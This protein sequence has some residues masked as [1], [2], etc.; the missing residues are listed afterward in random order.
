V[1]LES[2]ELAARR[3]DPAGSSALIAEFVD[4]P[5][6]S[7]FSAMTA[8]SGVA[9]K[10]YVSNK[11]DCR[12]RY[13]LASPTDVEK[14][15]TNVTNWP[16]ESWQSLV[17][18]EPVVVDPMEWAVRTSHAFGG[19]GGGGG[20]ATTVPVAVNTTG[21]SA[22]VEALKVFTPAL[23]PSVHEPTAAIPDASV[24]TLAPVTEPPPLV[25]AKLTV[26]PA[27]G[28]AFW[29]VTRTDGAGETTLFAALVSEVLVV[30]TIAVGTGGSTH[31]PPSQAMHASTR[32]VAIDLNAMRFDFFVV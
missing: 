15:S 25:T 18:S 1:T 16:S 14:K 23:V 26:T 24:A 6:S 7:S 19:G 29:S 31:F 8:P 17:A 21:V 27:I 2:N 28:A 22:P 13:P 32:A 30:A 3:Y 11:A 12:K 5:L 20:G 9:R 4:V 10:R